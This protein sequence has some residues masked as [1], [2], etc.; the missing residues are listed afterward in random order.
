MKDFLIVG[1]GVIG[2]LTAREL[3]DGGAS[4]IVLDRGQCGKEASWAGGG[5]V[6]PLYPWRYSAAVTALAQE[7]QRRYPALVQSLFAETGIDAELENT[8]L[9]MLDAGDAEQALT[10][11]RECNSSVQ[12]LSPEAIYRREPNLHKGFQH[13]LWM[14]HI[15]NVR[16][17]RLMQALVA[18]LRKN[19]R[20]D[21]VEQCCVKDFDV[22]AHGEGHRVRGV[23]VVAQ[24]VSQKLRADQFVVCAG[25]WSSQLLV[26]AAANIAIEP[27]K[28]QMLLYKPARR[29]LSSIVLTNGRYLIPRRDNHI[30]LGSTLEYAQFDKT[31]SNEALESLRESALALLPALADTPVLKQWAGLRPGAPNGIPYIGRLPEYENLS[32]NAGQFRNGLVLAPA[33]ASLLADVLLRRVP[34]VDPGPYQ[35]LGR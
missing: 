25:A 7:A 2:L 32:I 3:A 6:S 15:A 30:L 26:A 35:I 31:T 19:P 9:L 24:G 10:W 13:G 34:S 28:G 11:A 4:V 14:P 33:S 22:E 1:G 20:V 5:I 27:V 12:A 17:P 18:S 21:I 8:G 29:L 16:N 23:N